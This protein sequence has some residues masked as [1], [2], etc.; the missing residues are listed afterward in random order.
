[1]CIG[2]DDFVDMDKDGKSEIITLGFVRGADK[3]GKEHNYWG[4]NIYELVDDKMV[5][6]NEKY[7]GFPKYVWYPDKDNDKDTSHLSQE[8]RVA[9]TVQR[10][11]E[12]S[13]ETI[14]LKDNIFKHQ[15]LIWL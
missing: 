14:V 10:D 5:N 9:L 3:K 15:S 2:V 7:D 8:D 11:R 12:I 4:Y 1:M 6:A 13:Q